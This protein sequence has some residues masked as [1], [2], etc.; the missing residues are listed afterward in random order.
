MPHD[1]GPSAVLVLVLAATATAD[2]DDGNV[3]CRALVFVEIKSSLL[4]NLYTRLN[5]IQP[6]VLQWTNIG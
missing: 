4:W 6:P 5:D 2:D 1:D 3:A